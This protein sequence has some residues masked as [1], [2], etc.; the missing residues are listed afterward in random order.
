MINLSFLYFSSKIMYQIAILRE[1]IKEK[2]DEYLDHSES[3]T[4]STTDLW[5]LTESSE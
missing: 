3:L 4:N 2:V 5:K 1:F